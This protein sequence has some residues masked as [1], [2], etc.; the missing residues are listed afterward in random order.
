M[1]VSQKINKI[2][3]ISDLQ[4]HSYEQMFNVWNHFKLSSINQKKR[5]FRE[6]NLQESRQFLSFHFQLLVNR[7]N[8]KF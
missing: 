2:I 8:I 1:C 5:R 3:I 6:S 7:L 4:M